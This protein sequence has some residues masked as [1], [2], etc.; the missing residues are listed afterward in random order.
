MTSPL[1]LPKKNI[2]CKFTR[3]DFKGRVDAKPS[4]T[5]LKSRIPKNDLLG[6]EEKNPSSRKKWGIWWWIDWIFVE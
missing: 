1:R 3:Q 6:G 2:S 4:F 5:H